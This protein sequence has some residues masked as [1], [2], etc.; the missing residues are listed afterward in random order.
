[1]A[2]DNSLKT[3]PSN[4][5][6]GTSSWT[7]PGW[8]GKVYKASYKN[9]KDLR[10]NC[11]K[12]YC[13]FPWF[14][15]VGIDSSFYGPP[16]IRQLEYYAS[17]VPKD[18][19]WEA[20]VWEEITIPVYGKHKRYGAKA[21]KTNPFFLD[22]TSFTEKFL[23]PFL[24]ASCAPHLGAFIFQFQTFSGELGHTPQ[25]FFEELDKF[26]CKIPKELNYAVEIR[27]PSFLSPEYFEVLNRHKVTHCFNHWSF[28]PGLKQ[29]MKAAAD[30]GGIQADFFLARIL[31]PL[32]VNYASAVKKFSPYD[33]LLEPIPKMREDVLRLAKRG[34]ELN[35]KVY[36]LVNNRAEGYAPGTIEALGKNIIQSLS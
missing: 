17:Q 5:C 1:M 15:T 36:I 29:Q 4:I 20:K 27:N 8:R 22:A 19:R 26:F 31:T 32:G 6:F 10:Q 28:M 2:T 9:D 14:R 25:L 18:F 7:Y 23:P 16:R 12:E 13:A 21:G 24:S 11:L 3:L 34:I 33:K 35:K 30:A